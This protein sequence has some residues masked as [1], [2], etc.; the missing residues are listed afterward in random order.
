MKHMKSILLNF[1]LFGIVLLLFSCQNKKENAGEAVT[2]DMSSIIKQ[3]PQKMVLSQIV[4]KCEYV[5]LE[6]K[7]ECLIDFI[8]DL[9]LVDEYII[10]TTKRECLVFNRNNG[11]FVRKIGSY[12]RGPDEFATITHTV[13]S[14][15][16][17]YVLS[18]RKLL[19]FDINNGSLLSNVQNFDKNNIWYWDMIDS[20]HYIGSIPNLMGNS[21][22]RFMVGTL[23]GD[24]IYSFPNFSLFDFVGGL[25]A[26]ISS[27]NFQAQFYRFNNGLY[28][29]EYS[30][31][32]VFRVQ[33]LFTLTPAIIYNMGKKFPQEI[34]G[35]VNKIEQVID[36]YIFN[37]STF[38]TEKYILSK[39]SYNKKLYAIMYDKRT[40][41]CS[42]F[43]G[44][45]NLYL[46]LNNDIFEGFPCFF[47]KYVNNS[48][49]MATW[50]N[51]YIIKDFYEKQSK[52]NIKDNIKT[53]MNN[54]SDDDNPVIIIAH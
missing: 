25:E 13:L 54:L 48:G 15:S 28:V 21:K 3:K 18:A 12:G 31:D 26:R 37:E 7:E 6:T 8:R 35:D 41:Y 16:K 27:V 10:V 38:E 51:A 19:C 11:S 22:I 49:E 20:A 24:S 4:S 52:E 45:N 32:T 23:Q 33:D 36:D 53:F 42:F 39:F 1:L 34:R 2:F 47:P 29:K 50:F 30:N 44:E 46:G 43:D 9:Y 17:L 5:A 40:K 14:G